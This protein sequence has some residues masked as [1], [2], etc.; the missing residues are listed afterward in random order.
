VTLSPNAAQL[1]KM[2]PMSGASGVLRRRLAALLIDSAIVAAIVY[3]LGNVFGVERVTS[4]APLATGETEFASFT[5]TTALDWPV[6]AAAFVAYFALLEGLFWTT[7]G[8]LL[9]GLRVAMVDG[10]PPSW[11]AVAIRNVLRIVDALPFLYL[12]GGMSVLV[13]KNHQR[14][15]DRWGGTIVGP[16]SQSAR[17][18]PRW[19][20]K[21]SVVS[22]A[23]VAVAA[24]SL[25]F[26]YFGRPPL[27]LQGEWNTGAFGYQAEMSGY[28]LGRPDWA[29][30]RVTYP[31]TYHRR[32]G[33]DCRGHLTLL[34][35]GLLH[36][37]RFA[38]SD[39]HC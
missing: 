11:R 15:G 16:A 17:R 10:A 18:I 29:V 12:V 21:V 2:R 33:G 32:D 31:V 9:M 35:H 20:L 26:D 5:T 39:A 30:G 8:K 28:E 34:W 27:V 7:P 38:E 14:V 24:G 36:G 4:G 3:V 13:T 37:W 6:A 19:S 25:A 22:A 1:G 23:V